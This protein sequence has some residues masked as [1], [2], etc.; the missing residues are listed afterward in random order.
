MGRAAKCPVAPKRRRRLSNDRLA[1]D[2]LS[3]SHAI[4]VA[5][6]RP[7]WAAKCPIALKS[8]RHLSNDRLAVDRLSSS[9]AIAVAAHCRRAPAMTTH[10]CCSQEPS[11]HQAVLPS[12]ARPIIIEPTAPIEP[13]I[14]H[15]EPPTALI[16]EPTSLIELATSPIEPTMAAIE[17]TT[18]SIKPMM[19][20]RL[21]SIR[22][23]GQ[24]QQFVSPIVQRA[25]NEPQ[26]LSISTPSNFQGWSFS[27]LQHL[28]GCPH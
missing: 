25:P 26:L 23:P 19:R 11:T 1:V 17:P 21:D 28:Q 22:P 12:Q 3:S 9:H 5:A 27:A 18:A 6:H 13:T 8:R 16:T 10:R 2:R 15:I 14:A 7:P 20:S 4:A 24:R